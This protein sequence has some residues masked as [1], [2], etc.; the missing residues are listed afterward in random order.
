M[1]KVRWGKVTGI[2]LKGTGY[3]GKVKGVMLAGVRLRG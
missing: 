2:R 3:R 1:G